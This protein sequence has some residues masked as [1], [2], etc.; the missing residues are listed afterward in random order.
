MKGQLI[1]KQNCF[2]IYR[3]LWYFR[4]TCFRSV[5]CKNFKTSKR[6]F[7]KWPLTSQLSQK[8]IQNYNLRTSD[9]F[10]QIQSNLLSVTNE[11]IFW[12]AEIWITVISPIAFNKANY[13]Y[14]TYC[15]I[16]LFPTKKLKAIYFTRKSDKFLTH[17]ACLL[18]EIGAAATKAHCS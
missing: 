5:F 13:M 3:P 18:R 16:L 17:Y 14:L 4:L 7:E 2:K 10:V 11:T 15:F 1:S 6:H 12:G 9:F 8:G